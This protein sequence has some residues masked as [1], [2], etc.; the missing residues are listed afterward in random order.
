MFHKASLKLPA[1]YDAIIEVINTYLI[2]QADNFFYL[3]SS[4]KEIQNMN[5]MLFAFTDKGTDLLQ[6]MYQS[7]LP[8]G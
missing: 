2:V 3:L 5:L 8:R 7:L 6:D 4:M 1:H